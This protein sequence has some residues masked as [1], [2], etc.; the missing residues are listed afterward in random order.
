MHTLQRE[1]K[2]DLSVELHQLIA[3]NF[4]IRIFCFTEF[5]TG[6][7]NKAVAGNYFKIPIY[8]FEFKISSFANF[9]ILV[10]C[11][12][13][14]KLSQSAQKSRVWPEEISFNVSDKPNKEPFNE[15]LSEGFFTSLQ[16]S[17]SPSL[18]FAYNRT[19]LFRNSVLVLE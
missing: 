4:F 17:S 5:L 6:P 9:L 2:K 13:L 14:P 8:I 19:A 1:G 3:Y 11:Q 10:A 7:N 15:T 12:S 18:R 16:F